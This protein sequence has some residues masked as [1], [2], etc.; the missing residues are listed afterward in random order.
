MPS[1][2]RLT[3]ETANVELG[4]EF[5]RTHDGATPGSYVM[6]QISDTGVG[7]DA[8]T[9][10][11]IFEPFF[12]TKAVGA[13]TGLGLATV[14][15]IVKQS[16]GS[17]FATSEPGRGSSFALYLPQAVRPEVPEEALI[18]PHVSARG[19]ET[20]MVVEDEEAVQD[21]IERILGAAGYKTLILAS[22]PEALA[23][24]EHEKNPIDMLLT[25]VLLPG[26]LQGHDLARTVLALCPDLPV[27]FMSGYSRDALIHAGRLDEG[28]N[29]LEK[30]F[31]PKSLADTVREVLDRP[32]G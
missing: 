20:I 31:T 15:G 28:V 22:G 19:S 29:L 7:M 10:E 4:E 5:C 1:G 14:Y 3:L 2:G 12:T 18:P 24:L 8:A 26:A 25:D 17:I 21:L 23:A 30:P 13:G 27:L 32:R 6:L 9:Q 11:R 16:N